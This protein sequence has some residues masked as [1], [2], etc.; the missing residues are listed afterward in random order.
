MAHNGHNL[1]PKAAILAFVTE[2]A[3]LAE[4]LAFLT[5][6]YLVRYVKLVKHFV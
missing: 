2:L 4:C 6:Y 1:I 3:L 5:D